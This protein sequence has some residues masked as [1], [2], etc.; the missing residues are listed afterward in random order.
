[1][2]DSHLT[3]FDKASKAG[4]IIALGIV[5]GDIGTSPL[6]TMQSL[7]ENQGG[8]NQVSESFI[9]GSISLIIWTLTLIT[10]IKYVLIALKADNHHE[11]GIFSLFTLVR[12]ISPWLIIPAM[13]GGATLL[14]DGAL[15]PAVTV[16]SAIEGLKAVPG[17]SHIYQ[18][19]TNVII[20][21]LVILIVLF[22][23]QRFGTGFIGK[24]FGPV[25]FIWV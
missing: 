4:F 12:K 5:Y 18:N 24:I 25:M 1:M 19:Q 14:S 7:V 16:T 10:T 17:L 13:I 15:T 9:L 21:T 20:T 23:I 6:Y 11:G 3:A 22:G 2:S 8:V